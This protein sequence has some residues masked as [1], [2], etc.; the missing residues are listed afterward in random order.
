MHRTIFYLGLFVSV[1]SGMGLIAS[2]STSYMSLLL[3]GGIGAFVGLFL[4]IVLI[5][6]S[7][8]AYLR[9]SLIKTVFVAAGITLILAAV[10]GFVFP[11]YFG[12]VYNNENPI[13]LLM[14]LI[15]GVGF[16]IA[17]F[18]PD[19]D[20]VFNQKLSEY[21]SRAKQIPINLKKKYLH[22]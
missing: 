9:K 13:T 21:F 2:Q 19:T 1:M 20:P 14:I 10:T 4:A 18:E 15:D 16:L 12:L 22:S 6:F 11:T 8:L 5:H 3:P 17:Y 7:S